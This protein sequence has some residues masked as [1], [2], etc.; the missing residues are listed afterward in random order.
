MKQ[1]ADVQ[2][3][4][5]Q[6]GAEVLLLEAEREIDRLKLKYKR[7]FNIAN[8]YWMECVCNDSC[9]ICAKFTYERDN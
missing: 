4:D 2:S 1:Q 5:L 3:S 8:Q 6:V 9:E 7:L